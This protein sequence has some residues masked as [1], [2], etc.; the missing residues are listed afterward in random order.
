MSVYLWNVLLTIDQAANVIFAPVLNIVLRPKAARFGD[1]DE[2]LSSVFGKNVR[3]GECT[4]CKLICWLLGKI[5]PNHCQMS[6]EE[7]EGS[8]SL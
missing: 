2:T 6:T 3:K 7:D 5:D 8:R 1:P 4:G